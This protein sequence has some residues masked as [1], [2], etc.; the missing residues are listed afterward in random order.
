MLSWCPGVV[1]KIM[2]GVETIP[3]GNNR[4]QYRN[5]SNL[6]STTGI[7]KYCICLHIIKHFYIFILA[8]SELRTS[9]LHNFWYGDYLKISGAL[10]EIEN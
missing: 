10:P 4:A 5:N 6:N 2:H 7:S 3:G 9:G 1:Y 8:N